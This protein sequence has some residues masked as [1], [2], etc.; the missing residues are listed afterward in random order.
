VLDFSDMKIGAWLLSAA[1]AAGGLLLSGCGAATAPK[2]PAPTTNAPK[3]QAPTASALAGNWLLIGPMPTN[4][5]APT[6]TGLR[7]AMTFDVNGN[8]IVAAGVGSNFCDNVGSWFEFGGSGTPVTGTVAT[9]GSFILS[10]PP[11][12]SLGT[13]S[14]KGTIPQTSGGPWS[15][16]YAVSLTGALAPKCDTDLAGTFTATAFPLVSGVY[17]GTTNT[18]TIVNGVT[19]VTPVTF[20]VTLQQGGTVTDS[21]GKPLLSSSMLSGSIHVQGSPCFTSGVTSSAPVGKVE[22]NLVSATFTMDDGS[23]MLFSGSLADITETRL[24]ES[25]ASIT[26][27][28]CGSSIYQLPELDRQS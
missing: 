19:T 22:G 24:T 23:T 2:P 14:I 17:V 1:C 25:T 28:Q 15:G 9:D 3:P 12:G 13:I 26:G 6:T 10:T 16:D 7:L 18:K 8:D 4:L 21:S 27:G 5:V 11:N 20:Q